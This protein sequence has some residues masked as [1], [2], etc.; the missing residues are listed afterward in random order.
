M[1]LIGLLLRLLLQRDACFLGLPAS[2]YLVEAAPDFRDFLT[3]TL[4]LLPQMLADSLM[5]FMNYAF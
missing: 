5:I 2:D 3:Q 1:V 4:G